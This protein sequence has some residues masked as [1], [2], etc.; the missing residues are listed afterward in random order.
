MTHDEL[1]DRAARWLRNTRK[2]GVVA[3]E[4]Q[5]AAG[6]VPDAIG[7]KSYAS[8]LIECKVT[9]SDFLAD[10]KKFHRRY[11]EYGMGNHRY[12]MTPPGLL[13]SDELPEDWGLLEVD[14]RCVHVVKEPIAL[15]SATIARQERSLLVKLLRQAMEDQ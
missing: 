11:P 7:W 10:Q 2:C 12:Y 6:V 14:G 3:T 1:V 13:S 8:Y 4:E 9:R 5:S 15:G